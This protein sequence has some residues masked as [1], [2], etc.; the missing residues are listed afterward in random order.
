VSAVSEEAALSVTQAM[1]RARSA[2][3]SIRLR[4]VGEVSEFSDKAGYKAAYF[5]VCDD[6]ASMP[7]LMGRDE[8][9]ASGIQLTCGMPV[10]LTGRF[11]AY[12]PTGRMQFQVRSLA[13]AGEGQLRLQVAAL[14]RRLEYEGLMR[15]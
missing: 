15:L 14:A 2:L 8:Y 10:E 9:A 3:E 4:V 12:G 13:A 5:T 1:T 6:G 7:C 11:T